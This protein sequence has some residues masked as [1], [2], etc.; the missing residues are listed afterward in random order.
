MCSRDCGSP[1]SWTCARG[2][3]RTGTRTS[4]IGVGTTAT[5]FC[6]ALLDPL[7]VLPVAEMDFKVVHRH[8]RAGGVQLSGAV[9]ATNTGEVLVFDILSSLEVVGVRHGGQGFSI[10]SGITHHTFKGIVR[11]RLFQLAETGCQPVGWWGLHRHRVSQ[12]PKTGVK[13]YS[14]QRHQAAE[15]SVHQ[16]HRFV[17]VAGEGEVGTVYRTEVP[18]CVMLVLRWVGGRQCVFR[19][20]DRL[21]CHAKS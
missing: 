3:P 6:E 7:L 18:S 17:G 9:V 11:V 1:E 20:S 13:I 19:S 14:R 21:A 15:G 2:D 10:D 12:R 16:Q 8:A 5:R 4:A